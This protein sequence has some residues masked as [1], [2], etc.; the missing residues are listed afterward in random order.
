MTR[1][2]D[3]NPHRPEGADE[4][5][6]PDDQTPA[7]E[8]PQLDVEG[9]VIHPHGEQSDEGGHTP[10]E[11]AGQEQPADQVVPPGHEPSEDDEWIRQN[12]RMAIGER[13][14]DYSA[15]AERNQAE[16]A[17]QDEAQEE[18]SDQG[19]TEEEASYQGEE[20]D[21]AEAPAEQP[22]P[23]GEAMD[24][25]EAGDDLQPD[26]QNQVEQTSEGQEA[27]YPY[28]EGYGGGEYDPM[29]YGS[30]EGGY[31][32]GENP[33]QQY[34][35]TGESGY[36]GEGAQDGSTGE[37]TGEPSELAAQPPSA[38]TTG[39]EEDEDDDEEGGPKMTLGEHLEELRQRLIKA[40][41]GLA[42][43]M[44]ATIATAKIMITEL[45]A[46]PYNQVQIARGHPEE[47]L[48]VIGATTGFTIFFKV[49]LIAGIVVAAPWIFYQL[50]M[51]VAAGLYKK[52][53]RYVK[54]TVP[55]SAA[56]FVVGA[57]FYLLVAAQPMMY[58]LFSFND[59]MGIETKLT[60]DSHISLMTT[61]MLVFGLAFQTPLVVLILYKVGILAPET[62]KHYRRHVI[63]VILILAAV[64]TPPD[65]TAQLLLA[66]P[67]YLLYEL[68]MLLV[69]LAEKKRKRLEAAEGPKD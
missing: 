65:P 40:L 8:E 21:Q 2:E 36:T 13:E 15:W 24:G 9:R 20:Q 18:A 39:E 7:G 22:A 49:A 50:W 6:R 43:A 4:Q 47:K 64:L 17:G 68:G 25:V 59:W 3:D 10:S 32:S 45:L 33:D 54:M 67:I 57:L 27:E 5:A 58:F 61:M 19:E 55:F 69:Y 34:D 37:S 53:R 30:G 56:L 31:G 60:L 48:M 35:Y 11:Q 26:Q 14:G 29:T 16:Q 12:D 44:V 52:E 38:I 46:W 42:I 41:A 23:P 62:L 66:V 51:F 63:V 1:P 28:G